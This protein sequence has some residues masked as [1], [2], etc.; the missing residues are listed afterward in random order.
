MEAT[1][2]MHKD[3][4]ILSTIQYKVVL[5]VSAIL[6]LGVCIGAVVA[7]YALKYVSDSSKTEYNKDYLTGFSAG[8]EDA[9]NRIE[10]A[11]LERQ[12]TMYHLNGGVTSIQ[13]GEIRLHLQ[14][15]GNPFDETELLDR[16]I[17][18]S[19][20]TKIVK[21]TKSAADVF[22]R[23]DAVFGDIRVGNE[24]FVTASENIKRK[25]E[26]V[27]TIIYIRVSSK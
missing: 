4:N 25:T 14:T 16:T 13:D 12:N 3:Q 11:T 23:E 26:F 18:V 5:S 6:I 2:T 19:T 8:S 22:A 21:I 15:L 10:R 27:P 24:L 1:P 20:T 17:V 9:R 7:P